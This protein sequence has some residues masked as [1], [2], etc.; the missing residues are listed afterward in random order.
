MIR[1]FARAI[2]FSD[3]WVGSHYW[4]F[5][6]SCNVCE[7]EETRVGH[8]FSGSGGRVTEEAIW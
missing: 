4:A 5:S 2:V 6:P 1:P 7:K 8:V 3:E